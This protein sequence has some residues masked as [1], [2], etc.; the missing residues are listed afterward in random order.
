MPFEQV[1][2]LRGPVARG[3]NNYNDDNRRN[4]NLNNRP[5]NGLGMTLSCI[6]VILLAWFGDYGIVQELVSCIML[7]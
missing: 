7:L 4:V 5:S 2:Y 6:L 1:G 3:Y